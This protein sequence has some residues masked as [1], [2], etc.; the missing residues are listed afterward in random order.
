M[1]PT[2]L[3]KLIFLSLVLIA[4][5]VGPAAAQKK[6]QPILCETIRQDVVARLDVA[7]MWGRGW[8]NTECNF[9]FVV[10]GNVR[11]VID[12]YRYPTAEEAYDGFCS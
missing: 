12:A 1:N 8:S 11:V 4:I 6:S 9:N 3:G 5:F 2:K 10:Q 7:R